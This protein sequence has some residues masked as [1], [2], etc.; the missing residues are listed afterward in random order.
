MLDP[1]PH[2]SDGDRVTMQFWS[3]FSI[4]VGRLVNLGNV[5]PKVK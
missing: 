5:T 1:Q 4:N 3:I 2:Q